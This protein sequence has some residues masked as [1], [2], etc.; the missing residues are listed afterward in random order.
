M[1]GR[2][3]KI[4][5]EVM[6]NPVKFSYTYP[7]DENVFTSEAGTQLTNVKRLDRLTFSATWHCSSMLKKRLIRL[8]QTASVT[9]TIDDEDPVDGRLRLSGGPELVEDSESTPG[10]QGLWQVVCT[11]EGE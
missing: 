7:P 11:F 6:P 10:T 5:G 4:N 1:L 3:I 9:I 8:C 2:Y